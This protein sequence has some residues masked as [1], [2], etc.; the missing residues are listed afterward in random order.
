MMLPP[1]PKR[2]HRPWESG[3]AG[4]PL[5]LAA[6]DVQ[7]PQCAGRT[8]HLQAA[9][10]YGGVLS[11]EQAAPASAEV[12]ERHGWISCLIIYKHTPSA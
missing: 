4:K 9:L 10:G 6:R 8:A 5:V 7:H 11:A 3:P 1:T 2:L 12:A